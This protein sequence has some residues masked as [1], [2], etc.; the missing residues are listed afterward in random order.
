MV[1]LCWEV[2]HLQGFVNMRA[3]TLLTDFGV[4]DSY[5]G[6]NAHQALG[7]GRGGKVVVEMGQDNGLS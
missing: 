3:I 6:E 5:V 4:K 1:K 7:I 2:F